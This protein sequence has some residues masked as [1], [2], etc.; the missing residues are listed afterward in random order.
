RGEADLGVIKITQG[1]NGQYQWVLD[2]NGKLQKITKP[3][4]ATIKR[5]ELKRRLDQF[6]FI[7]PRSDIFTLTFEGIEKVEDKDCYVVKIESSIN[8]DVHRS[9]ININDFL[10]E[11]TV[12]SEGDNSSETLYG[13]YR[14]VEGLM[15]AFRT[16]QTSL[17]TGQVEE[18]TITRYDSNPNID[19]P[20]F[21]P[22]EE[23]GKDYSFTEGDSAENISFQFIGG[24][25]YIPVIVGCRQRLWILDTGAAM[26]VISKEFADELGLALQG[27]LKGKGAGGTVDL[28]LATLPGYSLPGIEFGEQTVAVI[29]M[30]ELIRHLG[31][32]IAGILGY[33]FLSRFV[34]KVD[35]AKELV[36]FYDP[37]TFEY[38]GD[39]HKVDVH[40]KNSVFMVE[41]SLDG[42]HSGTWLFDL[43]ASSVS[44]D[45]AY[46]RRNG[47][48]EM[49]GVESIGRGAANA[50]RAKKVKC[51][52]LEFAGFTVDNPPVSFSVSDSGGALP[53]DEIGILGNTLFRNFVLYCDYAG[54]RLIVEKGD[55]FNRPVPQD[56]S[57]LQL[58]RGQ[59]GELEILF[60][61]EGTPAAKA[62]LREKD[63]VKAINGIDVKYLDGLI[64]IRKMLQE[65][66]GTKYSF[67]VERDGRQKTL[68]LTLAGL[69]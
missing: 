3:D 34:M 68:N 62:G 69:F 24:H 10:L 15:V 41:A 4:E 43:G 5:K 55:D 30:K 50:F 44:L 26:S 17:Q 47:L 8:D 12:S 52:S 33:D 58:T 60:V 56:R 53:A 9:Y 22:P 32:D 48:A 46:A 29:D 40:M 64:A 2:A 6:E 11:K 36:S 31:V 37:E 63:V 45:G 65:E 23:G 67:V 20:F 35:Y 38:T 28:K 13:D 7:D 42:T 49:K 19:R 14:G 54:E 61:A 59:E 66:A 39:G 1:D 21:D 27:D 16:R 57:G 51:R 25:L 18:M